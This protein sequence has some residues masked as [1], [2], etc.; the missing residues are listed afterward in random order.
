DTPIALYY[1]TGSQVKNIEV[2][3]ARMSFGIGIRKSDS[4][5]LQTINAALDS[6]K[7]D[8]TLRKI[9]TDWG[10]YNAATAQAFTDRDP[11]SNDAAPRY[12]DYLDA[13]RTQRTFK[14][15]L[16][17]YLQYLPLLLEGA[18]VTLQISAL[19]MAIAVCLGLIMAVLRVFAP[20]VVAW[21]V[22]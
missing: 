18:L 14:E 8:G 20:R 2:A 21:P 12:R 13:I 4:E 7:K 9:Y 10:I 5:L 16:D 15:R 3:A 22:V 6:M 17:Q 11:V 1:A 19:S